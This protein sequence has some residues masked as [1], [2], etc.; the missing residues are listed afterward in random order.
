[1]N[2]SGWL[3]GTLLFLSGAAGLGH[4][5]LWTRRLVD[6]LGA[7]PGTFARVVGVFFVGLA[8]GSAWAA[9]RPAPPQGAWL[10]VAAAEGAVALLALPVLGAVQIGDALR[11]WLGSQGVD[12]VLPLGLIGPPAFA[13]GLVF[14]AVLTASGPG[15]RPLP[16][17]AWNTVG[18]LLGLAALTFWALPSLGLR[19]AALLTAA[20]NGAIACF[21][22]AQAQSAGS[23]PA[24]ASPTSSPAAEP[25][26]VVGTLGLAMASGAWIIGWEVALQQHLAQV[27][28][29]S[30][31]SGATVLA[32]VLLA[33]VVGSLWAARPIPTA[34]GPESQPGNRVR[35]ALLCAALAASTEPFLLHAL[36]PGLESVPYQLPPGAYYL[37]LA[38]LAF[39]LAVP[40]AAAMGSLFPTLLRQIGSGPGSGSRIAQ[41]LAVNGLGGWVGAELMSLV[42]LPQAGLWRPVILWALGAIALAASVPGR[43]RWIPSL[44]GVATLGILAAGIGVGRLPQ[45][46]PVPNSTVAEVRVGREG[47]VAA[48]HRQDDDWWI[49]FNNS[50]TLGGSRA[51]A[52]Q[53]RQAHLPLLLHGQAR[54]VALL[55]LATGSTAGGALLHPE[56][57]HVVAAELS[58]WVADFAHRHFRRF[59][60]DI[61]SDPRFTLALQD[62]RLLVRDHPQAYDVVIGDLFLPWRTGEGRLFSREHFAAVHR[63]LR[64]GG[65]YCQWLPCFQ[66]TRP[67][68]EGIVRTFQA[69]FPGAFLLRGDFYAEFPIVGVAAF[70]DGRGTAGLDWAAIEAECQRLRKGVKGRVTDGL[71]R[72]PEGVAMCLIGDLPPMPSGPENTLANGWLEWNAGRNIVGLREPW[73]I[74]VPAAERFRDWHR[75]Q[76]P[77]LSQRWREAHDAGQFFLTLEVATR[78][79]S[80]FARDLRSQI[81]GRL[82]LPLRADPAIDWRIWPGQVKPTALSGP[83]PPSPASPPLPPNP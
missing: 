53:E 15:V 82:P 70:A 46:T 47:V 78:A 71:V 74:G 20:V 80:G 43:A 66:L 4:Q 1:M 62:A 42:L 64:P 77:R 3:A 13:M 18:G 48:M 14:P 61:W 52:N 26:L 25:R 67:Q 72:Y 7:G 45:V 39:V 58:P 16:L 51:Q 41:L 79:G 59:N 34:A 49:T 29:N 56:V 75:A 33:L 36:R 69:E 38:G 31:F 28:I 11:P 60:R 40:G 6:V 21:A 65:L 55:G 73:F 23:L 44:L 17:Y 24:A 37:R 83:L 54:E 81:G 19:T 8:F 27:T 10:R 12:W 9:R 76:Q 57:T 32:A 50:Y 5:L 68:F 35:G 22:L 30:Q 2:R 63:S